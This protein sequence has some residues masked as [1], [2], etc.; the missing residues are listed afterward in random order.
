MLK[1][2][3]FGIKMPVFF[4]RSMLSGEKYIFSSEGCVEASAHHPWRKKTRFAA[5]LPPQVFSLKTDTGCEIL[6]GRLPIRSIFSSTFM[7]S[8]AKTQHFFKRNGCDIVFQA[9]RCTMDIVTIR[10]CALPRL[11][12]FLKIC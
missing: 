7:S 2:D 5:L 3:Y 10:Q 6:L 9:F 1:D 8:V 11:P 4:E 12:I